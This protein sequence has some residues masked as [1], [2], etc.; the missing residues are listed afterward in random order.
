MVNACIQLAGPRDAHMLL[1]VRQVL[2]LL[3]M[4][5]CRVESK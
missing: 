4:V 5:G 3:L 2:T 1:V